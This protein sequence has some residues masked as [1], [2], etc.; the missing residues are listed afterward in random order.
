MICLFFLTSCWDQLEVEERAFVYGVAIDL[1]ESSSSRGTEI[2]LTQQLIVPSAL[3]TTQGGGSGPAFRNLSY[4]GKTIIDTNREMLRQSSRKPDV[5]HL[6]VVLFSEDVAKEPQL[7]AQ[8][9][10]V[11]LREKDMRR[12]IKIAIA[13]EKAA[14]LLTVVPEQEKVPAEY[15]SKLLEA[16]GN[17]D[18][19]DLVRIGDIQEKLLIKESFALPRLSFM[20]PTTINYEGISIYN[21]H[22]ARIVGN[23]EG[24]EAKGLSLIIGKKHTGTINI[25]PEGKTATIE[26]LTIKSDISLQNKDIN[27]LK[28]LV[29]IDIEGLIAEQFGAEN[30]TETVVFNKFEESLKKEIEQ[31]TKKTFD[32]LQNHLQTDVIGFGSYLHHY[33]PELW[34]RVKDDWDSGENYFSQTA[35]DVSVNVNIDNPGSTNRTSV[36]GGSQ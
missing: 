30:V 4:S 14:E 3:I 28:F 21:G 5:T 34:K 12:G 8:L 16:K 18:I 20:N 17:L 33:H 2:E 29:K 32:T 25:E 22:Q 15:I 27:H 6:D 1:A 24:E 10:D 7:F 19:L 26:I 36:D 13:S 35:M 11:F 31:V 9:I 23:L